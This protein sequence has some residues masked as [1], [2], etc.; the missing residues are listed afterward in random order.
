[1]NGLVFALLGFML[2]SV[3][4]EIESNLNRG[5]LFGIS[6]LI[7]LLLLVIRFIWVYILHD[8]FTKNRVN[9]LEQFIMSRVHPEDS[10]GT[11][12]ENVSRS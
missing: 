8:T 10:N 12:E 5:I 2:P 3:Y 4:Q 1:M 11:D 9:P 6:V 7:V